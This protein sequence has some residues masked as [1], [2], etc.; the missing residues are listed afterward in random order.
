[1]NPAFVERLTLSDQRIA[2]MA[3]GLMRLPISRTL[4]AR[5][6]RRGGAPTAF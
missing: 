5:C 6:W 1:M 4:W 2:A 3:K